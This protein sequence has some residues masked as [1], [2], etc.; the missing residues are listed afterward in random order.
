MKNKTHL[1]ENTMQ[2]KKKTQTLYR[3]QEFS[4]KD[5]AFAH[6]SNG[7]KMRNRM[8]L[9]ESNNTHNVVFLQRGLATYTNKER[10]KVECGINH[11]YVDRIESL[12]AKDR[13]F[14]IDL[15]KPCLIFVKGFTCGNKAL[16]YYK[17]HGEFRVN[18]VQSILSR[19][20]YTIFTKT[21]DDCKVKA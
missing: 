11:I 18:S 6:V 14:R 3:G 16:A 20:D 2:L 8:M 19:N 15:N 12:R 7:R 13:P 5:D 10:K 21:A 4:T 1:K 9:T 17:F